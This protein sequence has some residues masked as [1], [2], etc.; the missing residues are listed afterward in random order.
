MNTIIVKSNIID[1]TIQIQIH[2]NPMIQTN[3]IHILPVHKRPFGSH[4]PSFSLLSVPLSTSAKVCRSE[5][6]PVRPSQ[7]RM[8]ISRSKVTTNLSLWPCTG[9]ITETGLSKRKYKKF[10]YQEFYSPLTKYSF[11]MLTG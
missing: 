2:L 8:L 1:K 11:C 4:F 7:V 9:M 10:N 5:I 6:F 3:N